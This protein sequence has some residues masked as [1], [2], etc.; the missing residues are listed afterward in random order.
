MR[1]NKYDDINF[2]NEYCKMPRSIW[3]LKAAGEWPVFQKMLPDLHNKRVLD[4][5]CGFGWHCQYAAEQENR[6]HWPVDRYFDE[7]I[8]KSIF[9]GEEVMKYHKTLT[10]YVNSLLKSGFELTGLV[11]PKVDAAFLKA[12]PNSKDEL[13]RPMFLIISARKN[14]LV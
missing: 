5:G 12:Y 9:L 6:L 7:G 2:F 14:K 3:G 4:L 8:R 1:E 11:E 13:R 10:T